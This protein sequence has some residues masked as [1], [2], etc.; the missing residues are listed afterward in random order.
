MTAYVGPMTSGAGAQAA[1][2]IYDVARLAGVAPSTVSRAFSRPG[3]VS[4]STAARV[5][6]VAE[7]L[8]YRA[9]AIG[10]APALNPTR[11]LAVLVTDVAN[12]FYDEIIRGAQRAAAAAGYMML[13]AN[14]QESGA[15][16]RDTLNRLIPAAEGILIGSSRMPDSALLTIAKQRPTV[17]LNRQMSAVPSIVRDNP[18]GVALALDHLASL[19]HQHVT[20]LAGPETSWADG[21]RWRSVLDI[22]PARGMSAQRIGPFPPTHEGGRAAAAY[23]PQPTTAVVA[24]ND[25]MAIGLITELTDSRRRVPEDIAV[26]GFDDIPVA[27]LIRPTLTTIAAPLSFMGEVGIRNL[28]A[29]I[30]GAQHHNPTGLVLP[31]QLMVRGSTGPHRAH[32]RLLAPH[33]GFFNPSG[34]APSH[35]DGQPAG[36]LASG[37]DALP[38][39]LHLTR[40]PKS[41]RIVRE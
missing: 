7:E 35:P 33:S 28:I 40:V 3:R 6:A 20:Y 37:G 1:P 23:L 38:S 30:N 10:S 26:I 18:R 14:T 8:G 22:A 4:A 32:H 5:R 34:P 25:L 12:P 24:Y 36:R 21:I 27:R 15:V 19:G 39:H 31:V 16:E 29:L 17:V 11:M 41:V 13:L 2:T 9:T